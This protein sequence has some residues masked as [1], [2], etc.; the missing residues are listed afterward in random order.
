MTTRQ[1]GSRWVTSAPSARTK[2]TCWSDTLRMDNSTTAP[3]TD[4]ATSHPP[5]KSTLAL[6]FSRPL[7]ME[8]RGK[9]L[10]LQNQHPPLRHWTKRQTFARRMWWRINMVSRGRQKTPKM[11]LKARSLMCK[12]FCFL[13]QTELVANQQQIR[14]GLKPRI[15]VSAK[16]ILV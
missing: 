8:K 5:A 7:C 10:R 1:E 12:S 4:T 16:V 13:T 6:H 9:A 3:A 11:I 14:T 2:S 15:P